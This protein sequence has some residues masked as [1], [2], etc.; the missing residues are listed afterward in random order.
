MARHDEAFTCDVERV[1]RFGGQRYGAIVIVIHRQA[2]SGMQTKAK[3]NEI[4]AGRTESRI[5]RE[6]NCLVEVESSPVEWKCRRLE[7]WQ[8]QY[9]ESRKSGI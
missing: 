3:P 6:G 2:A 8:L 1:I 7:I 9:V 4:L 5:G